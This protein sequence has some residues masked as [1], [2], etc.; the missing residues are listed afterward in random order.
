MFTMYLFKCQVVDM[1]WGVREEAI[2][3]HSSE[4]LCLKEIRACDEVSLGPT[5][6]V[7]VK[8]R[9]SSWRIPVE[10]PLS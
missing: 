9:M 3:D 5:F 4:E 10:L 8:L 2:V 6:V 1:R 7:S